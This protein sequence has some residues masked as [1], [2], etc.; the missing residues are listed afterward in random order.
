MAFRP[1]AASQR[2]AGS[3]ARRDGASERRDANLTQDP[4]VCQAIC[5]ISSALGFR[6]H[7][8]AIESAPR[9][10]CAAPLAADTEVRH[11][12]DGMRHTEHHVGL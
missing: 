5:S 4:G 7:C 3:A 1:A 2:G 8:Y 12:R 11:A 9:L 10:R 6:M